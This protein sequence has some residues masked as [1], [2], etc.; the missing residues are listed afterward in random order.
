MHLD[1]ISSVVTVIGE[2]Q[3]AALTVLPP[4]VAQDVVDWLPFIVMGY[5]VDF[6]FQKTSGEQFRSRRCKVSS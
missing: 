1:H 2:R 3:Q 4:T 5:S 6:S